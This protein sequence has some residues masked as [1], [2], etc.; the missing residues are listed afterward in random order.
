M[1]DVV[2]AMD[3]GNELEKKLIKEVRKRW[4]IWDLKDEVQGDDALQFDSFYN[5]F[6]APYFGCF[7]CDETRAGLKALDMD[8]DGLIEWNEFQVYLKWAVHEYDIKDVDGLLSITFRKGIIP[9]M[10]DELAEA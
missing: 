4:D 5:G 8:N 3:A 6:M 7:K 2:C 9:A 1:R 10:R